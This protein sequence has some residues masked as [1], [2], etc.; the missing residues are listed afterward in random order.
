MQYLSQCLPADCEFLSGISRTHPV[1]IQ[2]QSPHSSPYRNLHADTANGH[3]PRY[4]MLP[5][6][7][8]HVLPTPQHNL[9]VEK[10]TRTFHHLFCHLARHHAILR[11]HLRWHTQHLFLH[12]VLVCH[13]PSLKIIAGT[14]MCSDGSRYASTRTRFCCRNSHNSLSW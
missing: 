10:V 14:T 2:W 4:P 13:Q 12:L 6:S 5:I 9:G 1:H 3:H 8:P 7:P 11:N